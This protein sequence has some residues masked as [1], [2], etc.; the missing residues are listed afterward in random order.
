MYEAKQ[1]KECISKIIVKS[2]RRAQQQKKIIDR[3]FSPLQSF[4][5]FYTQRT[6]PIIDI[7]DEEQNGGHTIRNHVCT[8]RQAILRLQNAEQIPT[9]YW[10]NLE[11]AQEAIQQTI[12]SNWNTIRNWANIPGNAQ[13]GLAHPNQ[14]GVVLYQDL[15]PHQSDNAQM[16]IHKNQSARNSPTNVLVVTCYPTLN[17]TPQ[18][19]EAV[20]RIFHTD[21][22]WQSPKRKRE[23]QKHIERE[24]RKAKRKK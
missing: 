15:R 8:R 3:K 12:N 6:P 4:G 9:S 22:D 17:V 13:L 23:Q 10:Q 21:D 7:N 2:K 18:I 16:F 11:T 5:A 1:Q 19:G 20:R 24:T 14:N